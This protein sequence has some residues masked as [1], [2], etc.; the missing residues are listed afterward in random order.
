MRN[1]WNKSRIFLLNSFFI[2]HYDLVHHLTNDYTILLA[3][4]RN[5]PSDEKSIALI[6]ISTLI[7]SKQ[8][9]EMLSNQQLINSIFI[10]RKLLFL[11]LFRSVWLLSTFSRCESTRILLN[12]RFHTSPFRYFHDFENLNWNNYQR[13]SVHVINR[14]MGALCIQTLSILFEKWHIARKSTCVILNQMYHNQIRQTR[15]KTKVNN[16]SH[17]MKE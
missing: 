15:I 12:H 10:G 17:E 9:H 3:K 1:N 7:V 2:L 8:M 4:I 13:S 6:A 14:I 11:I 5:M 16:S